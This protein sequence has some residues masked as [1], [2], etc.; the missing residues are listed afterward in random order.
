[1][2]VS[3]SGAGWLFASVQFAFDLVGNAQEHLGRGTRFA[4]D[5]TIPAH[6]GGN[7]LTA[8]DG[9]VQIFQRA[10]SIDATAAQN[11]SDFFRHGHAASK[12]CRAQE[13][14]SAARYATRPIVAE[15][16]ARDGLE[17]V[18]PEPPEAVATLFFG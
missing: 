4:R 12:A 5:R 11:L 13:V 3:P 15:D 18:V 2:I 8:H 9:F 16:R 17:A 7:G 6:R 10:D 1:M 14:Q